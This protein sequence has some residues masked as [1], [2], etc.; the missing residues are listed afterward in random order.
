MVG[1]EL[2]RGGRVRAGVR[3]VTLVTFCRRAR[4]VAFRDPRGEGRAH[5]AMRDRRSGAYIF[6]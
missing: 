4:C 1:V 2:R 3:P 6:L 5:A